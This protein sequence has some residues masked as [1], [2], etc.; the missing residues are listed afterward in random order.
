MSNCSPLCETRVRRVC[1]VKRVEVHIGDY[2]D[3][4]SMKTALQGIDR[5][6]FVS[7]LYP[8]VQKMLDFTTTVR[9]RYSVRQFLPKPMTNDELRQITED[10]RYSSSA[11]NV[12]PWSVHIV[13]GETLL[14]LKKT[15]YTKI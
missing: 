2:A 3:L 6:L 1:G 4:D 8:N 5:L 15:H 9:S 11:T 12:Q 10:A 13:S 14:R 7:V